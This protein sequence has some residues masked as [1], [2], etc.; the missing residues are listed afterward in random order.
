MHLAFLNPQGNFDPADSHLTA[1]PDFGG[2][3]VYVKQVALAL[4]RLGHSVD[5]V[6]RRVDDTQWPEFA[7]VEEGYPDAPNVRIVRLPAGDTN[8]FLPKERLWPFL[9]RDWV[10]NILEFYRDS[11]PDAVTAHYG[12]GGLSAVL[13]RAATG[14]PFTFTAHSLGAQKLDK[15]LDTE[16][17][18]TL[19][20]QYNF[21]IRLEAE[22]LSMNHSG[23]NIVSTV[24]ERREQYAH[25]RYEPAIGV[26][27]DS[28]FAVVPPGVN[29]GTFDRDSESA[30]DREVARYVDERVSAATGR[31]TGLPAIVASSRLDPK[32]NIVALVEAYASSPALQRAAN[33]VLVT[34]SLDDPLHDA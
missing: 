22:R 33:L 1:H 6:T 4:G 12:D 3:L 28:R 25:P 20:K 31:R 24:L 26:S 18:E 13:V 15:L 19:D 30:A 7:S 9:V 23:V 5:I 21:G 17:L 34:G 32:K 8:A 10:P 27:D 16:S 11:A 29:L 14:I 2:Q